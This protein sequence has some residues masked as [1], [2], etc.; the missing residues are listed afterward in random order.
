MRSAFNFAINTLIFHYRLVLMY[1]PQQKCIR[2]AKLKLPDNE[3]EHLHTLTL[4]SLNI[5]DTKPQ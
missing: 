1:L 4:H 5:L 3:A 2:D